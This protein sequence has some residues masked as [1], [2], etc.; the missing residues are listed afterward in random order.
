MIEKKLRLG[1]LFAFYGQLLTDKQRDILEVYCNEDLSLGEISENQGISRQAVYDTIRRSEK[2]LEGYESKLGLLERF[3]S[4]EQKAKAL[5]AEIDYIE[6]EL[7]ANNGTLSIEEVKKLRQ[8]AK[9][10]IE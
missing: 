10:V 1:N 7:T 3:R 6:S 8:L 2:L 9:Q 4:T 5:I